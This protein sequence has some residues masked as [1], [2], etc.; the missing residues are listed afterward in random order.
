MIYPDHILLQNKPAEITHGDIKR[1]THVRKQNM[2][3]LPNTATASLRFDE[4]AIAICSN[5]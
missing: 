1:R 3:P 2:L 5:L 4:S